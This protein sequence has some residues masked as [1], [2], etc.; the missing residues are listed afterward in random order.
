[1]RARL[2]ATTAANLEDEVRGGRFRADLSRR[3]AAYRVSLTPLRERPDDIPDLVRA[4][5]QEVAAASGSTPRTYT[6]A[7]L[8]ALAS[9]PW[10]RNLAELREMV[11]RLHAIAPGTLARQEDVLRSV[12]FGPVAARLGRMDSLRVA[13]TR[14]EREYIAAVLDQ[15]RWHMVEAAA[16]L[17]IERANLYRKIR[18]LGLT[19]PTGGRA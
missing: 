2:V 10:P 18:Q 19:R 6:P 4:L 7:A 3:L 14:F 17:G 9:L 12:G 11:A 1:V 16:S 13:R 5:A 8:T 15:H